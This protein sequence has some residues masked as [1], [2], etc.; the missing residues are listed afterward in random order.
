VAA[1][2]GDAAPELRVERWL[3]EPGVKLSD[4]KGQRTYVIHFFNT[5]WPEARGFI[6][7]LSDL[8]AEYADR[9]VT[10]VGITNERPPAA[11]RFREKMGTRMTYAVGCDPQKATQREYCDAFKT[12]VKNSLFIVGKDGTIVWFGDSLY[13]AGRVLK[14]LMDGSFSLEHQRQRRK[15]E[16]DLHAAIAAREIDRAIAVADQCI[17]MDPADARMFIAK[18]SL[19]IEEKSDPAA[20]SSVARELGER[21]SDVEMLNF[22]AWQLLSNEKWRKACDPR[23]AL[24]LAEKAHKLS[25][26]KRWEITDTYARAVWE[27]TG[28]S[29]RAITLQ[30]EAIAM[31]RQTP[32][33]ELRVIEL[34]KNLNRYQ[35]GGEEKKADAPGR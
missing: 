32:G 3:S 17:A 35:S 8:A 16:A 12:D 24:A 1:D 23:L 5:W 19:L 15:L 34:E 10:I 21:V 7:A 25:E 4:G 9:G 26:G 22:V 33:N 27:A 29:A 11:Q 2:L 18:L 30:N 20:A 31:C 28:D 6:P 13:D 14:R